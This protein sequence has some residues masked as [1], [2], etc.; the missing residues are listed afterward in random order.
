MASL[1]TTCFVRIL[2]HV[3]GQN[4]YHPRLAARRTILKHHTLVKNPPQ[5]LPAKLRMRQCPANA[6]VTAA[7]VKKVHMLCDGRT[8]TMMCAAHHGN[9]VCHH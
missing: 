7:C 3:S 5:G 2:L 8:A 9:V 6:G 4:H 1:L